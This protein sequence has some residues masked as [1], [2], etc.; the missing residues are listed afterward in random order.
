MGSKAEN[1]ALL[2]FVCVDL[3][4]AVLASTADRSDT[5]DCRWRKA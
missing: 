2:F 5:G 1:W 4:F 3:F